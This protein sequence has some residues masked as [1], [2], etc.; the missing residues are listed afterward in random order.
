MTST[1]VSA[2]TGVWAWGNSVDPAVDE[3]GRGQADLAP[4]AIA[5][6]ARTRGLQRVFLNAP[7]ATNVGPMAVWFS[8]AVSTLAEA[9]V[10][11]SVLG[12]DAGWFDQ[13]HLAATWL[14]AARATAEVDSVQLDV[15]PWAGRP[16][17]ID[18]V[19]LAE[20]YLRLIE[21]V[22]DAAGSLPIGADLPWWLARTSYGGGTVFDALVAELDSVAIIAFSDTADGSA[23]IL[24]LAGPAVRAAAASGTPFTIGV[25]TDTP[26]VAG[27]AQYTFFDEGSAVLEAETAKVRAAL[28]GTPGY[29]GV[30]VEHLLAWNTLRP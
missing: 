26:E 10:A 27:G 6:V 19:L 9:G 20:G 11:V 23:G 16:E 13:P 14:T 3:R 22:R 5:R 12:G 18:P 17:P 4:A 21:A 15:E 8:D 1:H 7:W 2:I 25:E 29:Q 28:K 24:E 30:T